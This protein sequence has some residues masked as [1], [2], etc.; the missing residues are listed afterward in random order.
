MVGFINEFDLKG[1]AILT[2]GVGTLGKVFVNDKF[3]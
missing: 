3:A 1:F 2:E